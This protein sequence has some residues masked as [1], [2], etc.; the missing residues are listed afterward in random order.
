MQQ[1]MRFMAERCE[2]YRLIIMGAETKSFNVSRPPYWPQK[3]AWRKEEILQAAD[4]IVE[5]GKK[6]AQD[7]EWGKKTVQ[8]EVYKTSLDNFT[9]IENAYFQALEMKKVCIGK[10]KE[11]H[12]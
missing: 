5:A 2:L 8:Y 10:E 1:S 3:Q 6:E 12:N 9:W 11:G 7:P 4:R